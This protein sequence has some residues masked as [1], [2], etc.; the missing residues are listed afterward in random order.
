MAKEGWC[1]GFGVG[2]GYMKER[3]RFEGDSWPKNLDLGWFRGRLAWKWWSRW[4][5]KGY[6]ARIR[7]LSGLTGATTV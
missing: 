7:W 6:E 1:D 5:E 4:S 2:L 3:W